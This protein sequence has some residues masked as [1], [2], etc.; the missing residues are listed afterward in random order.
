MGQGQAERLEKMAKANEA[1]EE[2]VMR[3]AYRLR[4]AIFRVFSATAHGKRA[5]PSDLEILNEYLAKANAKMIVQP[6]GTGFRW[7]WRDDSSCGF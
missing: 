2:D 6:T 1:I 5:N 4:E 7:A 3:E